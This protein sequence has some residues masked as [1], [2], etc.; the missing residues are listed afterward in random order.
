MGFKVETGRVKANKKLY[1]MR[2]DIITG[3][4]IILAVLGFSFGITFKDALSI[5]AG[6][7]LALGLGAAS[8]FKTVSRDM[9]VDPKEFLWFMI[10]T[11]IDISVIALVHY[12]A[13]VV[14]PISQSMFEA[15]IFIGKFGALLIGVA[16][17]VLFCM[18]LF[19]YFMRMF[20]NNFVFAAFVNV[21]FFT[22]FHFAVY[23]S[24]PLALMIVGAGRFI[25][26]LSA[27]WTNRASPS[28]VGHGGWNFIVAS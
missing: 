27:W 1:Q 16:E 11:F 28:V 9:F 20:R 18:V 7:L 2:F 23:G 4:F 12:A 21:L 17:E 22:V 19:P 15:N 26:T 3:M 8:F 6:V 14:F 13:N 25:L 24:N 10:W 5:S